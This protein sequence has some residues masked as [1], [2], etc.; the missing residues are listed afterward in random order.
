VLLGSSAS[1]H[2]ARPWIAPLST[3]LR[4]ILRGEPRLPV[5]GICFGHQLI[6]HLCGGRV[7]YLDADRAKRAGV[8]R[9][10]LRGS[11]LVQGEGELSVVV[12]HREEVQRPG[13]D[14]AITAERPGVP[15]DGLE[16]RTL[17]VFSYQFHPEA[18]GDFA[19]RAGFDPARIDDRVRRDSQRL[20]GAFRE[21]VLRG[22]TEGP[23]QKKRADG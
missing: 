23:G 14:F 1:V 4:P 6:A 5:L 19:A 7:G 13:P 2:D 15:I 9:T 17:P 20:L 12:S 22:A 3:W 10:Q 8:E 18:R 16:H 11:R 21:C